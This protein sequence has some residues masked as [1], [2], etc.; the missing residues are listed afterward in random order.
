MGRL[1]APESPPGG[2]VCEAMFRQLSDDVASRYPVRRRSFLALQEGRMHR[3]PSDA[4]LVVARTPTLS[5]VGTRTHS[6]D[7]VTLYLWTAAVRLRDNR[8]HHIRSS[9]DS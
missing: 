3:Y 1:F 6:P 9:T 4:C 5:S 8:R 2:V 7:C